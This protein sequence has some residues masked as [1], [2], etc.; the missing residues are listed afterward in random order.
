MSHFFYCQDK[1]AP[2]LF[3]GMRLSDLSKVK[4][5][6]VELR[7]NH[8]PPNTQLREYSTIFNPQCLLYTHNKRCQVA[9]LECCGQDPGAVFLTFLKT[10]MITGI[11]GGLLLLGSLV[12]C[13]VP[14]GPNVRALGICSM[15]IL[16]L[17]QVKE[18]GL[19]KTGNEIIAS[20]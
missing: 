4:G 12:S 14:Y 6:V 18:W 1:W 19:S 20:I 5:L 17:H 10:H 7:L 11:R 3:I 16:Y 9:F 8:K 13:H 15:L 2:H